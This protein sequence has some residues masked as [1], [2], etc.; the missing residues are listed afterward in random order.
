MP[1]LS[2]D[3]S[4]TEVEE[5]GIVVD[6]D[7]K[8]SPFV[9]PTE[10]T[11][12]QTREGEGVDWRT[13]LWAAGMYDSDTEQGDGGDGIWPGEDRTSQPTMETASINLSRVDSLNLSFKSSNLGSDIDWEDLRWP[14]HPKPQALFGPP[15]ASL[16]AADSITHPQQQEQEPSPTEEEDD[17]SGGPT[18]TE[19]K[20]EAEGRE[21]R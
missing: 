13:K 7:P 2:Q 3:Q 4:A 15:A 6:P 19:T 16:K 11:L 21:E 8:L 17:T 9:D 20:H 5:T 14:A 18:A 1:C 10:F 12:L